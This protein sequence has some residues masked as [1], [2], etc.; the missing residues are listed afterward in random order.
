MV[1]SPST[2]VED[3]RTD[4]LVRDS[5]LY[6]RFRRIVTGQEVETLPGADD[7]ES[8]ASVIAAAVD[9][10]WAQLDPAAPFSGAGGVLEG[11]TFHLGLSTGVVH[12]RAFDANRAERTAERVNPRRE[13]ILTEWMGRAVVQT[14]GP[15]EQFA[16]QWQP[17]GCREETLLP[18]VVLDAEMKERLPYGSEVVEWSRKSRAR[19]V[20]TIA[21][22]DL[23]GWSDDGGTLAMVTLTLPGAWEVVA[24]D[25][26]AFKR[27][28]ERFRR[29]WVRA[30]GTPWR[31]L[32]KLEFQRRGAPHMH[33]LMRVPV[34]VKG[35]RFEDW[36]SS[37]WADVVD[38][39]DPVERMKHESAGTGVDYSGSRFRDPRRI[40]VYFL[41][42]SS[43]H[44]DGKEYQHVVPGLWQGRGKGPGRFWGYAGLRKAVVEVELTLEDWV[45]VRRI[46]RH[47]QRARIWTRD[48]QRAA[49]GLPGIDRRKSST[50][51]ARGSLTG[52]FV[53]MGDALGFAFDLARWLEDRRY[54]PGTCWG[55]TYAARYG[56]WCRCCG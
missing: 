23:S 55:S 36:L 29:R 31:A 27:H 11:R 25:G 6:E 17:L 26:K 19:M 15:L 38:H 54:G 7:V 37:T 49:R 45:Q 22:L 50:L 53:I 44:T 48:R 32:W 20:R 5:A 46:L 47:V 16:G 40:A 2:T 18:R 13:A 41:G 24:P 52:G 42:H 9:P 34:F 43:K 30:T 3:E 14:I 33:L 1:P 51:G 10:A 28:V 39:P 56:K 4:A 35:Q 8:V 21:S 12:V